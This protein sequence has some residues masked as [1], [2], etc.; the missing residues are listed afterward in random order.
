MEQPTFAD[1][2]YGQK[3]RKTRREEFLDK[4]ER[5]VPWQRLEERIEPHYFLGERGRNP[6]RWR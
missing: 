1:L 2:E 6:I 3:K 5:L 4:L